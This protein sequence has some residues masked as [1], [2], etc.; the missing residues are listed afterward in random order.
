MPCIPVLPL[1]SG[2]DRSH[3]LAN[4]ESRAGVRDVQ[5]PAICAGVHW[6]AYKVQRPAFAVQSV[7]RSPPV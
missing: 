2:V 5:E 7:K 1:L 6:P 4:V 3:P